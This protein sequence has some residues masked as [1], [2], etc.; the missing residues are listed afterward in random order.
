MLRMEEEGEELLALD[1]PFWRS[2]CCGVTEMLAGGRGCPFWG[3]GDRFYMG[4]R[5]DSHGVK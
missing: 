5:P 3:R 2:F 4:W 1:L